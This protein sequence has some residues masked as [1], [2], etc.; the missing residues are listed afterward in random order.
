MSKNVTK[1]LRHIGQQFIAASAVLL[2]STTPGFAKDNHALVESLLGLTPLT[3]QERSHWQNA[4]P[5]ENAAA[6]IAEARKR[7][8]ALSAE[9]KKGDCGVVVVSTLEPEK[10]IML[11]YPTLSQEAAHM[12]ALIEMRPHPDTVFNL[13]CGAIGSR[14]HT[15]TQELFKAHKDGKKQKVIPVAAPQALPPAQP[16]RQAA[17]S[18]STAGS[19][20]KEERVVPDIYIVQHPGKEKKDLYFAAHFDP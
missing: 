16:L 19:L 7:L 20:L 8:N 18:G 9:K 3:K 14:V 5:S 15:H 2:A 6:I 11:D 4:Q 10:R 17:S 12:T 13:G 1:T